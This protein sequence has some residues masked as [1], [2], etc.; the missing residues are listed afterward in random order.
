[1]RN[2]WFR[3]V[4]S[5]AIILSGLQVGVV[6]AQSLRRGIPTASVLSRYGLEV[7]WTGQA[8]LNPSRDTVEHFC[9]DEEL[10]FVQG[11][12]GVISAFDGETG[13]RRWAVRLGSYDGPSY[14]AVTNEELVL[15]VAGTYMYALDKLTG[16]ILWKIRLPGSPATGPS[17]DDTQV[18]VGTLD[19]SV[20]AFSLKRIR[21][22]YLE[23]RLPEWSYE[24]VTWRYQAALEVTSPPVPLELSVV[25]ASRDGSMYSVTKERR[26]LNYQ[27]E[28]NAPIVAPLALVGNSM[29]MASEDFNFYSINPANGSVEW[30][31]VSG[32]PIRKGPVA[33]GNSVYVQPDRGGLYSLDVGNGLQQWWQPRLRDFVSLI[34]TTVVAR[35]LDND[36][37]L[38]E[39]STG[40]LIG[41][42]PALYYDRHAVNDRSDRIYL[43][44]S[45]GQVMAIKEAG[46]SYPIYHRYPERRPILPEIAPEEEPM[47][48]P[49][50]ETDPAASD[51]SN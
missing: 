45:R 23:Q 18:Y 4:V 30:E 5:A 49:S 25:F 39:Q 48:A 16:D 27:F 7:A 50:S 3:N 40:R 35:D 8:V 33:L 17:V 47:D 13:H 44:T 37:A 29:F 1:M 42:I 12:N 11:T 20:Y 31:F 38:L 24:A 15:T 28:T 2:L 6:S 19:G 14:P 41:R 46:R 26:V 22:L 34:G 21:K 32:L 36:L 9:L 51:N 10:V 43:A